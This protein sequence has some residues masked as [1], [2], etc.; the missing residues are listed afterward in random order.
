MGLYI[1]D[2]S[3]GVN[4]NDNNVPIYGVKFTGVSSNDGTRL[5]DASSLS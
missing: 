5:Y 2:F 4:T 1:G 3:T